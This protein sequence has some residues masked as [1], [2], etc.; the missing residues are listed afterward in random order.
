MPQDRDRAR[1]RFIRYALV[2]VVVLAAAGTGAY[3]A[4]RAPA[5]APSAAPAAVQTVAVVRQDLSNSA[6]LDGT[7]GFGETQP[8]RGVRAGVVTWLPAAGTA[9]TRGQQLLRVD[10]RPIPLF[11][12]GIPLYRDLTQRNTVGRDVRM[13]ADNLAAL[14]YDIGVQPPPGTRVQVPAAAGS[15]DPGASTAPSRTPT[16]PVDVRAGEA[17]LTT[18]LIAAVRAWQARNDLPAD[19]SITVGDVVVLPGAVRVDSVAARPGSSTTADLM[20]VTSTTKVVTVSANVSQAATI[21]QGEQVTVTLPGGKAVGG[22]V[23]AVGTAGQPAAAD[24]AATGGDAKLAVTV[25]LDDLAAAG[26]LDSAAVKV[27]FPADIHRNVL[28]VPLGAL[29]ALSEGGY[30]VQKPGGHLIAVRTGMFA[31]GLVEVSGEG[32]E[33]GMRVV[34]TS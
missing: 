7:L 11:Y 33:A 6:T 19:G 21:D 16:T 32:L 3:W 22:R 12:G 27:D 34:T 15:P 20:S 30:A 23:A 31:R 2:A 5:A 28:T 1:A 4:T 14:G 17:V 26:P 10:D 18:A 25:T 9:V 8:I 29:V 13:I 24:G